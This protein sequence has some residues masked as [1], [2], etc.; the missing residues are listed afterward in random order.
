MT[1]HFEFTKFLHFLREF[2]SNILHVYIETRF[3]PRSYI[4][5]FWR[6]CM[7][8]S[9]F[10]PDISTQIRVA[11]TIT[12]R[13]FPQNSS[14]LQLMLKLNIQ[15]GNSVLVSGVPCLIS[16]GG[17]ETCLILYRQLS[18]KRATVRFVSEPGLCFLDNT[19]VHYYRCGCPCLR[20]HLYRNPFF[21]SHLLTSYLN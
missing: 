9:T 17:T 13:D 2:R 10:L 21:I 20:I 18:R 19:I 3:I 15:R 12:F 4:W 8:Q 7:L 11:G 14:T 16:V 1:F 5:E 6:C